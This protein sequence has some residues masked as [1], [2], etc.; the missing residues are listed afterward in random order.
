[1]RGEALIVDLLMRES[2]YDLN[3]VET[4]HSEGARIRKPVLRRT[5]EAPD[6]APEDD[7][8][9]ENGRNGEKHEA[10]KIGARRR[11]HRRRAE[12]QKHVAKRYRRRGTDHRLD[13]RGVGGEARQ[14][15]AR[16]RELEEGRR[17]FQNVF[18][19]VPPEIR[20]NPLAKPAYEEEPRRARNAEHQGD[21]DQGEEILVDES[22]IL[23][24]EAVVDH[25]AA[26][27]GDCERRKRRED[28]GNK[29]KRHHRTV[30][31]EKGQ[32]PQQRASTLGGLPAQRFFF[33]GLDD[34]IWC[35]AHKAL[36]WRS[37]SAFP[38]VR[39]REATLC[40]ARHP[41][42]VSARG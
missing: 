22:C 5:R 42:I 36:D 13:E 34:R 37:R 10:R 2:L 8:R 35:F 20:D 26:R 31:A 18:V 17:E 38:A 24:A 4:F 40:Q 9:Q 1:M 29:G 41:C 15:L 6:P 23:A 28:E 19:N 32:K 27:H 7:E 25:A 11:H 33:N 21:D 14:H 16:T 3:G 12:E 30:A 39:A